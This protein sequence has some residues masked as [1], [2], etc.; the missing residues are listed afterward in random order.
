M[1]GPVLGAAFTE[2]PSRVVCGPLAWIG[3]QRTCMCKRSPLPPTWHPSISLLFAIAVSSKTCSVDSPT[4]WPYLC[5][6]FLWLTLHSSVGPTMHFLRADLLHSWLLLP[7]RH[8]GVSLKCLL[9][10]TE[11]PGAA[12]FKRRAGASYVWAQVP[13]SDRTC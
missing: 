8:K 3:V 1:L 4:L 13:E 6:T 5:L 10:W 9:N 2:P 12:S 11:L 7:N